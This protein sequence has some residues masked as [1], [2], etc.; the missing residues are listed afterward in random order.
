MT[1]VVAEMVALGPGDGGVV[2][3]LQRSPQKVSATSTSHPTL[4]S[5]CILRASAARVRCTG[6]SP[7]GVDLLPSD[8]PPR[9]HSA[10]P[11]APQVQAPQD[12]RLAVLGQLRDGSSIELDFE[13]S[14]QGG[15]GPLVAT[16]GQSAVPAASAILPTPR[17]VN[18]RWRT[19]PNARGP[20]TLLAAVLGAVGKGCSRAGATSA[21]GVAATARSIGRA[22]TASGRSIGRGVAHAAGAVAAGAT[23]AATNAA[24]ASRVAALAPVHGACVAGKATGRFVARQGS[25][26]KGLA[27]AVATAASRAQAS[28][29]SRRAARAAATAQ[30]AAA[31]AVAAANAAAAAAAAAEAAAVAAAH[32][33]AARKAGPAPSAPPAAPEPSPSPSAPAAAPLP[34][35][36]GASAPASQPAREAAPSSSSVGVDNLSRPGVSVPALKA[37]PLTTPPLAAPLQ[38][39]AALV[40]AP[41]RRQPTQPAI[42]SRGAAASRRAGPLGW[43]LAAAAAAGGAALG[44]ARFGA[45][46]L[47]C[48]FLPGPAKLLVRQPVPPGV[49][50]WSRATRGS[51][52]VPCHQGFRAFPVS[53]GVPCWFLTPALQLRLRGR[54]VT[55]PDAPLPS[56]ILTLTVPYLARPQQS[57]A[58]QPPTHRLPLSLSSSPAGGG[59]PAD[60]AAAAAPE[61]AQPA[62]GRT[63]RRAAAAR[64]AAARRRRLGGRGAGRPARPLCRHRWHERRGAAAVPRDLAQRALLEPRDAHP[65]QVPPARD[66][67]QRTARVGA[68]AAS[69]ALR[70]L[71]GQHGDDF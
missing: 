4:L 61:G 46:S 16:S 23:V 29:R 7:Q 48:A 19:Q 55:A 5:T 47:L 42:S 54:R 36:T 20:G 51:V 69:P 21:S 38:P 66:G 63:R 11:V 52:L 70:C 15:P 33:P 27:V 45:A 18:K 2:D 56:P 6:A 24:R 37:R 28:R 35:A 1:D 64:G 41:P 39:P 12:E 30:R 34:A 68:S 13:L 62:R 40:A 17:H 26:L 10:T 60:G 59:F 3:K 32:I 50:C 65:D 22:A 9:L 8:R 31:Q 49:P 53:P 67:T 25:R 58:Q 44:A 14:P 71:P 57:H 43:P